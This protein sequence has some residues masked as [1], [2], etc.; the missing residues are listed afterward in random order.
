MKKLPEK[1]GYHANKGFI[2]SAIHALVYDC[3]TVEDF[4]EGWKVM[5]ETCNLHDNEWCVGCM[6]TEADVKSFSQMLPCSTTYVMEKQFQ[7]IYTISKFREVQ[8]E[9]IGKAYCNL[10]FTSEG[11]LGTLYVSWKGVMCHEQRK[12]KTF[13]VTYQRDN[14]EITCSCHLF[15]F[16]GI[17]CRH[18]I[19][20]MIRN[21]I[22][23]LSDKYI[24]YGDGEEMCEEPTRGSL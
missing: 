13:F 15:E 2:F 16:R 3:Q 19:S 8:Q 4:E 11:C 22:T 12:K 9:F 17:V 24:Y 10:I 14:C 23:Y 21:D 18:A 6:G 20:V 7:D 5:I 1:F